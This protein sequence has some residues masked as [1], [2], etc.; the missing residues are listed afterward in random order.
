M[1]NMHYSEAIFLL[2]E[3]LCKSCGTHIPPEVNDCPKCGKPFSW[4]LREKL[5][6]AAI[7]AYVSKEIVRDEAARALA[8]FKARKWCK[9]H[10]FQRTLTLLK[11]GRE[12]VCCTHCL[13]HAM[14]Q[15]AKPRSDYER[16]N[17]L[18][19]GTHGPRD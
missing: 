11:D 4:S 18:C 17:N 14:V 16:D 7:I 15:P 2:P 12:I 1:R 3:P 5:A 19:R 13:A 6:R 10:G 8:E 9:I